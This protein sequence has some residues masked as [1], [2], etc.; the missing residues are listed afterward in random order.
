MKKIK[1]WWNDKTLSFKKWWN[2]TIKKWL[3]KI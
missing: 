1:K 3:I 2:R